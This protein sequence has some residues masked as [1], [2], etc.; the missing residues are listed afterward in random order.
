MGSIR[1]AVDVRSARPPNLLI[2]TPRTKE[3][4]HTSGKVPL[5]KTLPV[6]QLGLA[7]RANIERG[8]VH[9]RAVL[10]STSKSYRKHRRLRSPTFDG[11]PP[12]RRSNGGSAMLMDDG[13]QISRARDAAIV[14]VKEVASLLKRNWD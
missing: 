2:V 10:T 11:S 12:C 14:K 1:V 13:I 9:D 5:E 6:D 4:H 3:G 8:S 7:P